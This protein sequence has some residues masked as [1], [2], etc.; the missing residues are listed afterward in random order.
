MA[1]EVK[2]DVVSSQDGTGKEQPKEDAKKD[3]TKKVEAKSDEKKESGF[4]KWWKGTKAKMDSDMLES[5]IQS[6][7]ATAHGTFDVYNYEGGLFNGYSV[8]GEIVD[9][10]LTYWAKD[11][12]K[13]FAVVVD[14]KD[15]K[16]YYAGTSEPV[17]LKVTYEGTEY[18]RKGLKATLDANVEEVH[19]VKAD[20]RYFLYKGNTAA[21]K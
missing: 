15:N 17:D 4:S 11:P 14:R 1:D 8:N 12:I 9:G 21:K 19:V 2:K 16:A 13:E 20:K 18:T 3:E 10:A 7:Y 6:A 5:H